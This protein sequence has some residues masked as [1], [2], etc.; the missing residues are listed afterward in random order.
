MFQRL[1]RESLILLAQVMAFATA[2]LLIGGVLVWKPGYGQEWESRFLQRYPKL[3]LPRRRQ[4]VT[5][6][7]Y[8]WLLRCTGI[9]LLLGG[10]ALWGLVGYSIACINGCIRR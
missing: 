1:N 8:L 2:F 7:A 3:N 9:V 5:S 10:V 4:L 6:G